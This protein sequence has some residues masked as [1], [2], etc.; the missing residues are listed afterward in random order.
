MSKVFVFSLYMFYLQFIS[1]LG[2]EAFLAI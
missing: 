1:F 2:K